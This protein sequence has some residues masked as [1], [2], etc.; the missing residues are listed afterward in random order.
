MFELLTETDIEEV[1]ERAKKRLRFARIDEQTLKFVREAG[2]I[3]LPHKPSIVEKLY[4]SI[5]SDNTLKEITFTYSNEERLKKI[6]SEYI[7][8]FFRA[9]VNQQY[10]D[11]SISIGKVNSRFHITPELF[12]P[13]YQLFVQIITNILIEKLSN[14]PN[15]LTDYINAVQKMASYDLQLIVQTYVDRTETD[16]L[17]RI[18]VMLNR[19]CRSDTTKQLIFSMEKQI[20]EIHNVTANSE[21]ISASI[22]YIANNIEKVAEITNDGMQSA[23]KSKET[24]QKSLTNIHEIGKVFHSLQDNIYYNH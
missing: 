19:I 24:I 15:R 13:A 18:S 6:L 20:D 4:S 5:V 3:I 21:E 14:K 16:F 2:E 8:R 9:E 11:S 12:I 23:E 22:E 7:D 17:N 10:I 1:N